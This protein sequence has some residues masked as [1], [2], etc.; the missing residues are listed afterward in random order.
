MAV[1]N[2]LSLLFLCLLAGM[3]GARAEIV[4]DLYS[5][6]VPVAGSD[7]SSL[8]SASREAM[9]QV[10]L[11]M[12]G[13]AETLSLE[14]I[15][16][17][18]Q[19]ARKYVQQY[20][21]LGGQG[22]E[23]LAARFEFD[24][25][26]MTR[27]LTN[28]GAPVWTAN[29]PPVLAWV[30]LEDASGRRF[31]G[32]DSDPELLALLQRE[33][34]RRG[35]PLRFPL[36]DLA[37]AAALDPDDAWRQDSSALIEASARYGV[38][39]VLAGRLA[40]LSTGAWVGDWAYLNDT[41]RLNRTVTANDA[42]AFLEVAATLV[43]EDMAARYAV[44]TTSRVASGGVLMQVRGIRDYADYAGVISWLESLELIEHANVERISG[45]LI[46]LRLAA[47]A[48]AAQLSPIIELNQRLIPAPIAQTEGVL[49]YQ[50]RD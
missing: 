7:Q 20:A 10:L 30:V 33:F 21:F 18:I 9:A 1:R 47:Q 31:L 24:G 2:F 4:R 38:S 12:S 25:T 6:E 44:E 16:S 13:S 37:D 46:E 22:G 48:D 8:D 45:E 49:V 14:G 42:Q 39:D 41:R 23:P 26:V 36:F 35:V 32:R 11:K 5:A 43:A 17:E 15:R 29:R 50:W 34:S 19:S 27:L 3:P 28:A 40:V